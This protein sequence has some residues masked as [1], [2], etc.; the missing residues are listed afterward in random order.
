MGRS[1]EKLFENLIGIYV[2]ILIVVVIFTASVTV[3]EPKVRE[4]CL[5]QS[6]GAEV[7]AFRNSVVSTKAHVFRG[8]GPGNSICA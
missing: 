4:S 2:V 7:S 8:L 1:P 5:G 3:I 6:T